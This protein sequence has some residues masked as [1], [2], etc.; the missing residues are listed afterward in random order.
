MARIIFLSIWANKCN[1]FVGADDSVGPFCCV[2]YCFV[3]RGLC[4]PPRQAT[5]GLPYRED[6]IVLPCFFAKNVLYNL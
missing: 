1:S 4:P 3:G 2:D 5:Q 6:S